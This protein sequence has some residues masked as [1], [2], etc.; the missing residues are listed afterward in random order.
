MIDRVRK[1][2]VMPIEFGSNKPGMQAG[3]PLKGD[4]LYA[5]ET[6]WRNASWSAARYAENLITLGVHKQI[7]NRITEPFV[8]ISSVITSTEW[9]NFFKLR[10]H[11]AAQPEIHALAIAMKEAMD[12]STPE[13]LA[14]GDW[15]LPYILEDE[16]EY[17]LSYLRKWSAA[18]CARVSYDNHDGTTCDHVKDEVLADDLADSEPGHWSPFEHQATPSTKFEMIDNFQSFMS[19]R[20]MIGIERRN[21]GQHNQMAE[22]LSSKGVS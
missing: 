12:A 19:S 20:H 14:V 11:P 9:D 4:E 15:H 13:I 3:E 6:V 18:R 2:P 5:A 22:E 17:E 1:D 8:Q 16:Q 10:I 7:A 21:E